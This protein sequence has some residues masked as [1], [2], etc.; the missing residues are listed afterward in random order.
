M[1]S[2]ITS[3][4]DHGGPF[5]S[6]AG[7]SSSSHGS[8]EIKIQ[9]RINSVIVGRADGKNILYFNPYF[10]S[11]DIH[12]GGPRRLSEF[13]I[14]TGGSAVAVGEKENQLDLGLFD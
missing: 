9:R 2:S 12:R 3:G 5:Y 8:H 10:I 7:K 13:L 6:R 14:A 1:M 4:Q 11:Y